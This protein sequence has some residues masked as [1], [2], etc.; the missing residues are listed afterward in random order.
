MG[1]PITWDLSKKLERFG[2]SVQAQIIGHL[3]SKMEMTI[4]GYG[5][6]IMMN[7]KKCLERKANNSINLTRIKFGSILT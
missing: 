4:F 1:S 2:Q 5:L 7:M 6:E 3:L